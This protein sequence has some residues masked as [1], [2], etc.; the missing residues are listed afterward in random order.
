VAVI[1]VAGDAR[2]GPYRRHTPGNALERGEHNLAAFQRG[3]RCPQC[4]D[5]RR[6]YD[7]VRRVALMYASTGQGRW[8]VPIGPARRHVWALRRAGLS[9]KT[10]AARAGLPVPTVEGIATHGAPGAGTSPATPSW[11]WSRERLARRRLPRSRV[12]LVRG[13]RVR[14]RRRRPHLSVLSRPSAVRR[15]RP[16]SL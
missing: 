1:D 11:P 12:D 3:C 6:H 13:R 4:R 16:R 9:I 2:R 5:A 7:R 8:K 10:I 14:R 15:R